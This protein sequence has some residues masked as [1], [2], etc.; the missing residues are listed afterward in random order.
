MRTGSR[1][2]TPRLNVR[3]LAFHSWCAMLIMTVLFPCPTPAETAKVPVIDVTDLYHPHQDVGDNFDILAAYALPQLDLKAVILDTTDRFR[4]VLTAQEDPTYN[5]PTGPRDPGFIPVIQLNAIF[6]RNIPCAVGPFRAMRSPT[7][8]LPD[9]PAF[10]QWGIRLILDTLRDSP[11]KVDIVSFGSARPLA[12]AFNREP[13]LMRSKVRRIHLCAGATSPA[14]LEWN[15]QLDPHAI[16]R[17]L[18][19]DLP[20]AL[21]PCATQ[22][23]PFALGRH[24]C[25]WKLENLQFVPTLH[26]L[27][28]SY[29]AFAFSRSTRMDFLRYLESPA[30]PE[31]LRAIADR[32]H[33]VWETGVWLQVAGLRLVRRADGSSRIVPTDAVRPD[34]TVLPNELRPCTLDVRDNGLFNFILTD[35]PTNFLMYDRGDAVENQRALREALPELYRSF[36]P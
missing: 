26:P 34:D 8:T 36:K 35:R 22:D 27:L 10:Q 2:D 14:Y 23:G 5:D 18:R 17:L 31:T 7:D 32:P 16:V 15:V 4:R 25:Y 6:G 12:V 21:Y 11:T 29:L 24:N 28:R 30:S 13:V 1:V 9:I 19:S 3:L 33:N 20:I